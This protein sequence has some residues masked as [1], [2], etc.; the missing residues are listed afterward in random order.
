MGRRRRQVYATPHTL[1]GSRFCQIWQAQYTSVC[2]MHSVLVSPAR[3]RY[4]YGLDSTGRGVARLPPLT[5]FALEDNQSSASARTHLIQGTSTVKVRSSAAGGHG[6]TS[7]QNPTD[8]PAFTELEPEVPTSH[9]TYPMR[10]GTSSKS[11]VE[12]PHS[13]SRLPA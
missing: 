13:S 3:R 7:A 9:R 10:S 5:L 2:C 12:I 11:N 6:D 8:H 1:Y 4:M